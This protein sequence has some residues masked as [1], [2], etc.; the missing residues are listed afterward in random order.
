MGKALGI[1]ALI[2]GVIGIVSSLIS[3]LPIPFVILWY[4]PLATSI[5]G[6]IC[7]GIGIKKDDSPGLA[8]TGLVLGSVGLIIWIIFFVIFL[9]H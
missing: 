4:V 7:G 2:F 9:L 8:I 6:I 5:V 3:F 1:V